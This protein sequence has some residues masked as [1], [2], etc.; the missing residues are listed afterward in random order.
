MWKIRIVIVC[1]SLMLGYVQVF[2]QVSRLES[3]EFIDYASDSFRD[4]EFKDS[5]ALYTTIVQILV[6]KKHPEGTELTVTDSIS[7]EV[8]LSIKKLI[9]FDFKKLMAKNDQVA[10]QFPIAIS[11]ISSKEDGNA[12][13]VWDLAPKIATM[14]NAEPLDNKGRHVILLSPL[15]YTKSL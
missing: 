4:T 3:R 10:F 2:S 6:S 8:M 1:L 11:I 13:A 12:I 7:N 9:N 15:I 5:N 14:F